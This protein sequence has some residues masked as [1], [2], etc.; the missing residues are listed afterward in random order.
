M[1]SHAFLSLGVLSPLK[2]PVTGNE[3]THSNDDVQV[4]LTRRVQVDPGEKHLSDKLL[5]TATI[6]SML[7]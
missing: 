7:L 5:Q 4:A 2:N 1:Q 3:N 6:L